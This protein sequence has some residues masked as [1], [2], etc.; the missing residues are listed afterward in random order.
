[1]AAKAVISNGYRWR[2]ALIGVVCLLFAAWSAYDGFVKYPRLNDHARQ[3]V[4]YQQDNGEGWQETWP[5]YAREHNLPE[6]PHPPKGDFSMIAQYV[7]LAITLPIGL[8]FTYLFLASLNRWVA[9]DEAGLSSSGGEQVPYDS[10][11]TLDKK[12]W[13]NKG[14]AVVTYTAD[15][16]ER[17][18]V[19]DDWKFERDPTDQIL[20]EVEQ[21]LQPD[22]IIGDLPESEKIAESEDGPADGSDEGGGDGTPSE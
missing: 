15:Q 6:I 8:W 21:R 5:D 22:Q 20:I 2:L 7:Q 4:E 12:R 3:Y 9:S 16:G 11:T 10:I 18:F 17:R 1:M 13:E 14:I 19:I